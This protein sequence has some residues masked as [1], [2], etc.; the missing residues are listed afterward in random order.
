MS[1]PRYAERIGYLESVLLQLSD[2]NH[3]L[4]AQW[5]LDRYREQYAAQLGAG[6]DGG[7]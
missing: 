6:K 3:A 2:P 5:W 4:D 1:D 7:A